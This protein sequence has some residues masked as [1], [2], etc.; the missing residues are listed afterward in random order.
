MSKVYIVSRHASTV[1]V[2]REL[3]KDSNTE[4]IVRDH[5]NDIN[6]IEDNSIVIGNM[7][8]ELM[9]Q[10]K[11]NK[12]CTVFIVSLNIPREL[13]GKELSKEELLKYM[14]IYE[15][16]KIKLTEYIFTF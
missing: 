15:V 6:E 11:N 3:F 16:T 4:V 12:N 8:L 2:L 9:S 13:R 1:E 14:K 10:L 7:P 5:I